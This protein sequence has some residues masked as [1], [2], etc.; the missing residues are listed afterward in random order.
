[1][2]L[3]VKYVLIGLPYPG[4][5]PLHDGHVGKSSG[6]QQSNPASPP[7]EQDVKH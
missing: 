4:K 2:Q 3:L 6:Y 7:S 1:M 5:A